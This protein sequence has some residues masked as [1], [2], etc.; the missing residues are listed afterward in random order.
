MGGTLDYSTTANSNTSV[1]GVSTAEGMLAGGVNNAMRAM[2]ADSRKW[3]L[4]WSGV[5]TA[6]AS[7]AYTLTS[8][9]GIS[10]YA[11]GQR[12][13]FRADRAN[14]GAATLNVDSRGAKSIRRMDGSAAVALTSGDLVANG[15]YD[16][17]YIAADD[18]FV[19]V[20]SF[21]NLP[22]LTATVAELNYVDGVTSAIQ[23]QLDGKQALDADLT[24]IAALSRTRGDLIRGGAAAWE[25]VALGTVGQVLTSDGTDAVWD[26]PA[27]SGM[28]MV[29]SSSTWTGGSQTVTGLGGYRRIHILGD[30][31]TVDVS[32]NRLLRVG[33]SGGG[34]LSSSIYLRNNGTLTT[35]LRIA[36]SSTAARSF[37]LVIEQF[38][39]TDGA[40]P[41]RMQSDQATNSDA[42]CG[43][44]ST[45]QFDRI[46]I[47]PDANNINGGTLYVWGEN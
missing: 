11:D 19:V 39:T 32:A 14:T 44:I 28:T 16:V 46:Q 22:G 17:V 9:Q 43:I 13:S 35:S 30:R 27:V 20:N 42:A 18:I 45:A 24:A 12:F 31:T 29:S 8:N 40:K 4:D 38:N 10:A 21:G 26:D 15:V 1:G 2:M 25:R 23:T 36:D 47:L 41:I 34:I 37:Y 3:Q 6:G 33:T 7:N 5:T